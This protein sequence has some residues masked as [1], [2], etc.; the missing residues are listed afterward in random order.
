MDYIQILKAL[1]LF[2]S[3][4]QTLKVNLSPEDANYEICKIFEVVNEFSQVATEIAK[5]NSSE[6][7][8]S[9]WKIIKN[10]KYEILKSAI[11]TDL[12]EKYK[13]QLRSFTEY[14]K[15]KKY[16]ESIFRS[17]LS[18]NDVIR[19]T[20]RKLEECVRFSEDNETFNLFLGRLELIA[21]TLKEKSSEET[22]EIFI[23]DAFFRNLSPQL[24]TFLSDNG[25]KD[26][27]VTE[28]AKFLDEREKYH[29]TSQARTL[30]KANVN[31]LES[32]SNSKAKE[33]KSEIEA[34]KE[35]IAVLTDLVKIS[36]NPSAPEINKVGVSG[37]KT[38]N[39]P[40]V[41][42][43]L[44]WKSRTNSRVVRCQ[45]CGVLGHSKENCRKTCRL[46]C[47]RCGKMGHLQAVCRFAKND[48]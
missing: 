12:N 30:A 33:E 1:E 41:Q 6:T 15:L 31:H 4:E 40:H 29:S 21:E 25:K 26:L 19:N 27:S 3:R 44:G 20:R 10:G 24:K 17:S 7:K 42:P 23:R 16:L 14:E 37:Q 5:S 32:S 18:K 13:I 38:P 8:T 39:L 35:Q 9:I 34:L 46:I 48:Q 43:R 22:A 11:A 2:K 28:M 36:L 47:H 45:E